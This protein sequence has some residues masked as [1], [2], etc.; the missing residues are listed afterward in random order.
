MI[1][2]CFLVSVINFLIQ[3]FLETSV[4]I[5]PCGN[6]RKDSVEFSL[7]EVLDDLNLVFL[8]NGY[9]TFILYP[10]MNLPSIN[11]TFIIPA[12][13]SLYDWRSDNDFLGNNHYPIFIRF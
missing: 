11:L 5:I 8:N 10:S 4:L 7:V 12:L 1:L 9:S 13:T 2:K 6:P 3:F